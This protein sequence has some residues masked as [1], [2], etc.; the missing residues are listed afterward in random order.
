MPGGGTI[1]APG[2]GVSGQPDGPRGAF[3]TGERIIYPL[4]G[5]GRVDA[6]CIE[7]IDAQPQC[8]YRFVLE[9]KTKGEVLVPVA[10]AKA[11]GLRPV[12]Q[13]S[14]VLSIPKTLSGLFLRRL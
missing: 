11:L 2:G 3:H 10:S 7:V 8:Y 13:A 6:L 5:I 9:G 14:Q 1:T 12:L 4:Y